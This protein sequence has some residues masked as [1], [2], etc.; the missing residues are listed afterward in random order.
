MVS[1]SFI[2]AIFGI[3]LVTILTNGRENYYCRA[4]S[5][6][7][8]TSSCMSPIRCNDT[9]DIECV[10]DAACRGFDIICATEKECNVF[11]MDTKACE[12]A[13]I[14][15]SSDNMANLYCGANAGD[16]EACKG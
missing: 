12:N 2:L 6:A 7:N 13:N 1:T 3:L 15:L 10:G 14:F 9:C 4:G 5:D 16:R 8:E 11:C